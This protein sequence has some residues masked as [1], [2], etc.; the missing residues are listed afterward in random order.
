MT[1]AAWIAI[2]AL[3]VDVALLFA[4]AWALDR[5]ERAERHIRWLNHLANELRA[6]YG[7]QIAQTRR[8]AMRCVETRGRVS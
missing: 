5:A 3:L 1:T 6:D 8:M 7:S 2:V 4:L